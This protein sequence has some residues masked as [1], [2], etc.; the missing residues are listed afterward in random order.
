MIDYNQFVTRNQLDLRHYELKFEKCERWLNSGK[1]RDTEEGRKEYALLLHDPSTFAYLH[2]K[3]DGKRLKF[4]PY[5][6][7]IANDSYRFKYFR[8]ANQTGKSLLLDA[9]EARNL[10]LDHGHGHNAAIVSKSL[11]QSTFQMRRIKAI[12]NTMPEIQWSDVKGQTDS[13]SVIS[14][15]IKDSKGNLKYT[16]YLICAPCTEGL[17]GY[18]LYSLNLDEFE[19]WEVDQKHFFN[20]IAQPRTYT[21]KGNITVFTNPNGQNSFGAELEEQK[22]LNGNRKWHVY[23]FDYLDKPGNT[24]EEYD[25]LKNELPRWE[26]ESTVAAIRSLSD[27]NYFTP[28]EI[29]K[30]EDLSL[31][32]LSLIGKHSFFFLDVG[33]T[34]DQCCLE[35]GYVELKEGFDYDKTIDQN[36]P[37]IEVFI[38]IIHL[39]PVGYPLSRVIGSTSEKM[40]TDG[41]HQE[42]TVK[43]YLTEYSVGNIQPEFG[44]DATGNK[45]MIPILEE[46][47]ISYADVEFS[48]PMKSAY[49]VRFKYLMEKHLLHRIKH[50][51]WDEQARQVVATRSARG[52]LLINAKGE[53][54]KKGGA[55]EGEGGSK[56]TPDDCLDATAGL[57]FLMDPYDTKYAPASLEVI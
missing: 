46:L 9:I 39:Y 12:L 28:D 21:T 6:D 51:E 26:F 57:L 36:K 8:S 35:G 34:K 44:F 1:Y 50:K 22:L 42:K 40:D 52:Y 4:Y 24:Q 29:E 45:G 23:I 10:I 55:L 37:F 7:I 53:Q 43:D 38:P 30:S 15:D 49:W 48:G 13:L 33:H 27:R 25:E 31:N 18:D 11:P 32:S 14:V 41:W 20:Q 47:K 54:Q 3:V 16:N 2:Q 19:F 17:L 5:Q 56:T